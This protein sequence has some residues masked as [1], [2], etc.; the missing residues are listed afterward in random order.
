MGILEETML[1]TDIDTWRQE[2]V[3][4]TWEWAFLLRAVGAGK[5]IAKLW[6]G[7]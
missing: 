7:G 2:G 1:S 4:S 6:A 5:D 3:W